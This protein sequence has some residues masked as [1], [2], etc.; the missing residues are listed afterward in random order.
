MQ[1]EAE[2]YDD[3]ERVRAAKARRAAADKSGL[4][5]AQARSMPPI[6]RTNAYSS[7]AVTGSPMTTRAARIGS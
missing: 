7:G 5:R 1:T 6:Q 3:L 4:S 2:F